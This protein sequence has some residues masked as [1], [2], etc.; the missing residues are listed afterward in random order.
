MLGISSSRNRQKRLL[1]MMGREKLDVVV[2]ALPHHVY[3]FSGY[4]PFWVHESAFVL[5]A[6]GAARLLCGKEPDVPVAADDLTVFD[7]NWLGTVR[8][9]QPAV[10][11]RR[12]L[13]LWPEHYRVGV[14]TSLVGSFLCSSNV[15]RID[16][17]LWQLR[18]RK[19]PD[20]LLLIEKAIACTRAMHERARQMVEPGVSELEVFAELQAVAV[21]KAAEPL[22]PAYLGND[23]ACGAPGGPPRA[24]RSA[25]EGELY[26][27]DLGPAYRGYFSDNSRTIAV[28]RKPTED[29]LK[30]W[31]TVTDALRIVER[32][33]R[34]GVKCRHIFQAVNEHYRDRTGAGL[35]HHLGHGVGL[36]PHEY[37]HLNPM[38][39]D[40]LQEGEVFTA[41]PGLYGPE[42]GGGMRIENQYLVTPDGV[43]NLTPFPMEL[44]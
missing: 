35:P 28:D 42:L 36:Q 27:L 12:L 32:M 21:R 34:P 33:A 26:I 37:P 43:E 19:D 23:F 44:A 18:R 6:G 2:V 38:W 9:G 14:D 4:L 40:T 15:R 10:V 41:E 24:G 3:Y 17:D 7:S 16:E 29:Q 8:Q 25:K 5:F 1:E 11:A 39:D 20:E 30:A 22:Y 31:L 13:E